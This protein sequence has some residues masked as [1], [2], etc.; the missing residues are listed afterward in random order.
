MTAKNL[1]LASAITMLLFV[2]KA[3]AQWTSEASIN[4]QTETAFLAGSDRPDIV[5]S[6]TDGSYFVR[7]VQ[8]DFQGRY[9]YAMYVQKIDKRGYRLWGDNGIRI[10]TLSGTARYKDAMAV[11]MN[12]NLIVATQNTRVDQ[13][14]QFPIVYKIDG[15]SGKTLWS[16]GIDSSI[17]YQALAPT[18]GITRSNDIIVTWNNS[19]SLGGSSTRDGVFM[20][21]INGATGSFMWP[22]RIAL[23]DDFTRMGL[24]P[25]PIVL[26][27]GSFMVTWEYRPAGSAGSAPFN[28]V[29]Q[30]FDMNGTALWKAPTEISPS[31]LIA[32]GS[33]S[34][35]FNDKQGGVI[36]S[37]MKTGV[38]GAE[39]YAQRID[40]ATGANKW[41]V[42][43]RLVARNALGASSSDAGTVYDEVNKKLWFAIIHDIPNAGIR[44][45]RFYL[46]GL[47]L[48]GKLVYGDSTNG[49][50]ILPLSDGTA[51][52]SRQSINMRNTGDGLVLVYA[53]G[54]APA[55]T[56]VKA[57]K[58]DYTGKYAWTMGDSIITVSSVPGI[59]SGTL[60]D[61]VPVDSQLVIAMNTSKGFQLAQNI[62]NS[63]V[64]GGNLG[65][66][67]VRQTISFDTT[68]LYITYGDAV[69]FLGGTSNT[70][71]TPEYTVDNSDV[72]TVDDNNNIDVIS[73]GTFHVRAYFPGTD[74]Y[75]SKTSTP[76]TIVV[77][78]RPMTIIAENKSI[79]YGHDIPE[80][81]MTF[82]D[83][84]KGD[85]VMSFSKLPTIV[86]PAVTKSPIGVYPITLQGGVS[87]KYEP[88]LVYGTLTVYPSGGTDN[89]KLE[90]YC[91]STTT[92]Q[93]NIYST[94]QQ[95]GLLQLIDMSGKMLWSQQMQ[96]PAF[97]TNTQ[98]PV[99]SVSPGVYVVRFVGSSS[100][101]NQKVKIK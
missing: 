43:S 93:V 4:T 40:T 37:Y 47:D 5:A 101:L 49:P 79:A 32:P 27:D 19:V 7:W 24:F 45:D 33:A 83:F 85:D 54:M 77:R 26:S 50:E 63:K 56:F 68:T 35:Y 42:D 72:A 61:Y 78:K 9:N 10:D 16:R 89:D 55:K 82:H 6:P 67:T 20:Q 53:E 64:T 69:P 96:V 57:L 58:V 3:A 46:Q 84:V 2:E 92:L 15:K 90:A 94:Q 73:A 17:D 13:Y 88:V 8:I 21:K 48:N 99:Y 25:Q 91:S 70:G 98:I 29:A 76:K 86:T 65:N 41:G 23:Q 97:T 74:V 34:K 75:I 38:K 59:T 11:D 28:L 39:V 52:K 51:S 95:T 60:S 12:G 100:I 31:N 18:V 80:L 71:I 22:G 81:T 66:G 36:V 30:K 87:T 44:G 14:R 62:K 1:I